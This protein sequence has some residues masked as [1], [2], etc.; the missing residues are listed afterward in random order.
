MA[1][2]GP[3]GTAPAAARASAGS[4]AGQLKFAPSEDFHRVVRKR[5]DEYFR[6]TGLSPRDDPRMYRKGAIALAWLVVSYVLLVFVADALWQAALGVLSLGAAI[7]CVGF[8]V[9]HDGAHHSCSDR[10]W[11]NKLAASTLDLLGGSSYIWERKHNTVHHTYANITGYDD[12]IDVG[13][14]GRLSPQQKRL[15]LHRYQHIYIWPFYGLV[16]F[17]WF[18]YDDYRD[19]LR[20]R[21]GDYRIAR[22]RGRD[23]A[24]FVGGKLTFIALAFAVPLLRH[25][26][27][28]VALGY[29]GVF[30][31]EGLVMGVVFQLAH[32]VGDASFPMP[33]TGTGRMNSGWAAH[34]V[35][36][37]VDYARGNRFVTWFVGGLNYQIEH[38]LLPQICHVHYPALA[39]I[40]ERTCREFGLRYKARQ[41]FSAAI[42]A[43]YRWLR[44]MG[45]PSAA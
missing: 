22:P 16:P 9:M 28:A 20:G 2:K 4:T 29:L 42:V 45:R 14:L 37:A 6:E 25:S 43:H 7:A 5:V 3:G 17:K 35:E 36:T 13:W 8:N 18:L 12:D 10:A 39:G 30:A 27:A 26:P 44:E 11:V 19:A 33:D 38:H 40:V 15:P 34:Q 41:T 24:L 23:L 31:V 1:T 32:C 21:I